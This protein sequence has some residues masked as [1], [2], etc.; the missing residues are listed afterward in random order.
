MK[1]LWF[2]VG[3]ASLILYSCGT[4]P[5]YGRVSYA[6]APTIINVSEYDPKEKQRRGSSY[7]PLNQAALKRNG[8]LGLI[9]RC[10]KGRHIDRKCADFLVGAERQNFLLGTYFYLL[11]DDNPTA[12][13]ERYINR[14]KQ[15]KY[16]KGLRTKKILLCADIHPKCRA[17]QI[18]SYLKHIHRLTG[19]RPVVYL[20][21][22]NSL[23][24]TL[25]TASSSQKNFLRKH[26]YWLALYSTD[27][28][29][30]KT[31][32]QLTE[33]SGVWNNWV[34]WQYGG[35][36]W[37]NGRSKPYHYRGGNWQTPRYFGSLSQPLERNG[38]NGSTKELYA[39]WDKHSWT[40]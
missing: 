12:T 34:M 10:G 22:S 23:R 16:S 8:A 29:T 19:V 6:E 38:F 3:L 4:S 37:K 33:G 31:P 30:Y 7:T 15:I 2:I 9:A 40:W 14:L 27:H 25:R 13:A 1:S 28:K 20:E 24:R 36:W 32:R 11:P 17:S 35:V 5:E 18:V 26:P 39:F 21:N